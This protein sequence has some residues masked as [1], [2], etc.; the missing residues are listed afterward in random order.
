MP[1]TSSSSLPTSEDVIAVKDQIRHAVD[2]NVLQ[3]SYERTA[4][5]AFK[6]AE[7]LA[8]APAREVAET[9]A[10]KAKLA[11]L[12]KPKTKAAAQ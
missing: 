1:P 6:V 10:L 11:Q 8:E 4:Q 3:Q 9:A 5:G 2:L 7:Y 12:E